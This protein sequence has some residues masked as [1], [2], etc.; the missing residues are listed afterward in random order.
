MPTYGNLHTKKTW[1]RL[2]QDLQDIMRKW[3]KQD[4]MPPLFQDSLDTRRVKFRYAV[5]GRWVDLE[6]RRFRTPEQNLAAICEALDAVRKAEQR[7]LGELL[8]VASAVYALPKGDDSTLHATIGARP[9]MSKEELL[10]AFRAAQMRTHPDKGGD[11]N[12]F[13]KVMAAGEA[14]GLRDST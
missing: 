6:C 13:R 14:L 11:S 1:R 9:G 2:L 8:A 7:G 12:E 4:Y 5:N 3:G 10:T